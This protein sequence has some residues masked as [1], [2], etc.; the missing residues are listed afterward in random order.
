M[1]KEGSNNKN[2]VKNLNICSML[3]CDNDQISQVIFVDIELCCY[4]HKDGGK[5]IRFKVLK[6]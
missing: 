5:T 4:L 6:T 2:D 1:P 3:I